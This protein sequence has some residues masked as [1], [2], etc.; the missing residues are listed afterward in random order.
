MRFAE[1]RQVISFFLFILLQGMVFKNIILFD[2]AF[3]FIYIYFLLG[4]PIDLRPITAVLLGFAT[5]ISIDFF[6]DTG[7]IHAAASVLIM[8]LRSS[9]LNSITPQ[10]G[11]DVGISPSIRISGFLWYAGYALPVIFVHQLT[12]FFI[13]AYGFDLFWFTLYKAFLS[14]IFTFVMCTVIQVLFVRR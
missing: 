13:E 12:L 3:C 2:Y 10:G 1:I 5:G 9:W 14:T 6:Y 7:G 11:Y 8:F 4:L